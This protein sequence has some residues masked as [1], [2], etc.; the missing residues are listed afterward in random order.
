[1]LPFLSS[2]WRDKA[3]FFVGF[4]PDLN[5]DARSVNYGP[6]SA[7]NPASG[8][9]PF[10]QNTNTYYTTARVDIQASKKIRVFGSWLYQLQKQ[11]G[12]QL[13]FADS[14]HA[15]QLHHGRK[16]NSICLQ[17]TLPRPMATT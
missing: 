7:G 6:A 11:Y 4:N 1:M 12:E 14:V 15:I 10:S 13:P 8:V 2:G 3:F 17:E 16:D 5:R 9:V